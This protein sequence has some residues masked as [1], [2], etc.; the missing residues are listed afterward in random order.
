MTDWHAGL[1]H[2]AARVIHRL[3]VP[4]PGHG[5]ANG[6]DDL[7][8]D[9]PRGL[10]GELLGPGAR[11]DRDGVDAL[12]LGHL[13]DLDRVQVRVVPAAADLDR[14]RDADRGPHGP[15]DPRGGGHVAHE[16]RALAL[17]G[18]PLDRAAHVEVH[19][20]GPQGLA[21][22]RGLGERVGMLAE[23]L[24]RERALGRVVGGRGDRVR[25][26]VEDRGGVHLLGGREPAPALPRHEAEGRVG[27]ARHGREPREPA[28][29]DVADSHGVDCLGGR[30]WAQACAARGQRQ[31]PA[32]SGKMT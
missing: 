25:G 3:D 7:G 24:H 30:L 28:H 14:Q 22:G 15:K 12:G 16:R 11:V 29:L 27:R 17:A 6:V 10:P 9:R 23:E 8:D 32:P 4:V 31:W 19:D 18:D 13:R 2:H 26:L 20:V 1:R 21:S 5:D